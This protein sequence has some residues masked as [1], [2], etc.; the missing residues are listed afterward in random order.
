MIHFG[1]M[2]ITGIMDIIP[3]IRDGALALGGEARIIITA[4]LIIMVTMIIGILIA[5]AIIPGH[6]GMVTIIIIMVIMI[7]M[8]IH[9]I[10]MEPGTGI[11]RI[12]G[13]IVV[14][15]IQLQ[16]HRELQLEV[17]EQ[18]HLVLHVAEI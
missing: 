17:H 13:F 16:E 8:D 6:I 1:M 3:I 7:T 18:L 12:P 15:L 4:I 11:P 9:H 5:I 14:R 10:I 2:I